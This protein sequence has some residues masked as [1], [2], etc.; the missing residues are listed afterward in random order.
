MLIPDA[1]LLIYAYDA[2]CPAHTRARAWLERV[3]SGDEPVGIPWIVV[4]AFVRLMTHPTLSDKPMTVEQCRSAVSG[5]LAVSHVRLLTP[6]P[7]TI[8]ILFDMLAA[9]GT[10]G[11]LTTDALIAAHALEHGARVYSND[12][13]FGRFPDIVW[14][15]PLA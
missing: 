9:V 10:G 8:R 13:D 12:R 6:T 2:T 5:W 1:N 11:N 4:M 3:L 15:N 14:R 7:A